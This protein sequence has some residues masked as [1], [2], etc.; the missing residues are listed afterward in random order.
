MTKA[1]CFGVLGAA[2]P[3]VANYFGF[4]L[5]TNF[6]N[7]LWFA[8]FGMA[9]YFLYT[10]LSGGVKVFKIITIPFRGLFKTNKE[11]VIIRE[12]LPEEEKKKR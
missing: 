7:L 10:V 8:I 5:S 9:G 6:S 1:I 11:K 12:Q 3:V 4:S 2:F